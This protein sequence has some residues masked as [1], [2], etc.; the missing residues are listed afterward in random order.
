MQSPKWL[1]GSLN[2]QFNR[3]IVVSPGGSIISFDAKNSRTA[4]YRVTEIGSKNFAS[5]SVGVMMSGTTP[6]ST[7]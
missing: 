3:I 7:P 4:K 2:F 1:G 5:E 6:I